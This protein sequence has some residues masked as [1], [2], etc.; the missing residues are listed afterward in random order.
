MISLEFS[1]F[2]V[3]KFLLDILFFV[4]HSATECTLFY[5]TVSMFSRYEQY[6]YFFVLFSCTDD[7]VL[8]MGP[9]Q[10]ICTF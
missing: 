2:G 3:A 1:E 4:Q 6:R 8:R 9:F 7:L 5:V 10:V